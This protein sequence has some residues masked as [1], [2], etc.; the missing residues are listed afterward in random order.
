MIKRV[1]YDTNLKDTRGSR[2]FMSILVKVLS[3]YSGLKNQP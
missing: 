1:F 2:Y 3:R